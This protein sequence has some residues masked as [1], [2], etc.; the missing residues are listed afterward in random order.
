MVGG[1]D[2][3][4]NEIIN[5]L[6]PTRPGDAVNKHYSCSKLSITGGTTTGDI[7]M[8]GNNKVTRLQDPLLLGDAVN[9]NY[10]I[11]RFLQEHLYLVYTRQYVISHA[12]CF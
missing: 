5:V 11:N 8:N 6:L 7:N 12:K 10:L 9:Y 3:A 4:N 2:M 1:I